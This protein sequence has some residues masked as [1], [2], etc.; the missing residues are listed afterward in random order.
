MTE[1][2]LACKN[3]TYKRVL[4]GCDDAFRHLSLAGFSAFKL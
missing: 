1:P 4:A 3:I 2:G